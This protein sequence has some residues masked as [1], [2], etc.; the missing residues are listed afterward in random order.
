MC[1]D[2]KKGIQAMLSKLFKKNNNHRWD[3]SHKMFLSLFRT[4]SIIEFSQVGAAFIDGLVISR[5][6]GPEAMAAHGIVN[7]I[8]SILG[9][10]SGLLA[11]GMQTKCS[12]AIGRGNRKDFS[13]FFS[14]TVYVG[15][16]VSV[17]AAIAVICFAKP[18][19][20]MLG[21]SGNAANLLEPASDYLWGIGLGVPAIIME[22]IFAPACQL[23]SGR[24]TIQNAALIDAAANII[25]DVVAVK[26]GLGILGVAL[27]TAFARYLNLICQLTHF[28]KKDRMLHFVKPDIPVKE[29]LLMLVNGSEKAI[30]RASNTIRP[31]V[32]NTIIIAYGGTTAMSVLSVRNNFSNFAEILGSGIAAATALLV[33]VYYGEINGEAIDET[34]AYSKKM[35]GI[36]SGS[37][38]ILMLIF[39]RQIAGLYITEDGEILN[40]ATFVIRMLALQNPLQ[41]LIARRI[42]Y[43]QSIHRKNNMNLLILAAQLIFVV[44]S[45][46]VLGKLFGVYGILASYTASDALSL[47]AVGIFYAV[48]SKKAVPTRKD[49]LNLPPEFDLG[50]GDEISLD[51]RD[52][53]DVSLGSTQIAL[54]CKGHKLNPKIANYAALSFE[55]LSAN[56]IEYG[57]PQNR[58]NN[59]TID[60]RAVITEDTFVIRLRDNCPEYDVTKH[61]AEVNAADADI[62][63]NIGIRIVSNVASDISYLHTFETNCVILRFN[64]SES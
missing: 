64:L 8:Y 63:R 39:A 1:D 54:F 6:L 38:C 55:E 32:L 49:L 45:S 22:A 5:F 56:I 16:I 24:K 51:I 50:P 4:G 20:V 18:F 21:A 14:I 25:L 17:I 7:P 11:I 61:I 47:L 40:M 9:I 53:D 36:F 27:A 37:T 31:I 10:I 62:T 30:K 58:S 33:G 13:R 48:K 60:F 12:Q 29:F 2:R 42:K 41:A 23:D 35:I 52:M 3:I 59:P 44:I 46:V 19:T 57:F 26:V 34:D 43:L 15:A 28:L